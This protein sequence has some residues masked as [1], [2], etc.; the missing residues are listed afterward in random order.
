MLI[1]HQKSAV[2]LHWL[3]TGCACCP[4]KRCMSV[5]HEVSSCQAEVCCQSIAP[6]ATPSMLV[7]HYLRI[8]T[9]PEVHVSEVNPLSTGRNHLPARCV[10]SDNTFVRNA[11]RRRASATTCAIPMAN[12]SPFLTPRVSQFPISLSFSSHRRR[13]QSQ[14]AI[15][16]LQGSRAWAM[17]QTW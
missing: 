8:T 14:C 9:R 1:S 4:G 3:K 7:T 17:L 13:L 15:S 11:R 2:L 16:S 12:G 5:D 6:P 10:S